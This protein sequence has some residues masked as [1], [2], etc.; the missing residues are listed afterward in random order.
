MSIFSRFTIIFLW[1]LKKMNVTLQVLIV[2]V[3]S[4]VKINFR[5]PQKF[6][7]IVSFFNFMRNHEFESREPKFRLYKFSIPPKLRM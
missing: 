3:I 5:I 4:L 1:K 7:K 6:P 2:F